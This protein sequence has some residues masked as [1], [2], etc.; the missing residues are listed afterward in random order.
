MSWTSIVRLAELGGA[1]RHTAGPVCVLADENGDWHAVASRCP[2]MG[3]PMEKGTLRKGVLT[4]AWHSWEFDLG[5]GGCYRGACADLP[6][7][8]LRIRDGAIEVDLDHHAAGSQEA[9]ITELR[10]RL[11]EGDRYQIARTLASALEDGI[12]PRT[13]ASA[14]ASHGIS[15]AIAAHQNSTA[16]RE[17]AAVTAAARLS[18]RFTGRDRLLPLLQGSLQVGNNVGSRR[19]ILPLPGAPSVARRAALLGRYVED[20]SELALERLL[21][22]WPRSDRERD[23]RLLR[24]ALGPEFL[25]RPEVPIDLVEAIDATRWLGDQPD[26]HATLVAW[27]LGKNRGDP[28]GE[29]RDAVA[30]L[31][32]HLDALPSAAAADAEVTERLGAVYAAHAPAQAL[33]AV[34][35]ILRSTSAR[36]VIGAFLVLETRRL[37]RLRPNNGGMWGSAI[38]GVRLAE[39]LQRLEGELPERT[40]ALGAIHL[41]WHA[42]SSRWLPLGKPWSDEHPAPGS[43]AAY[44][45]AVGAQDTATARA[46]GVA[47]AGR[48]RAGAAPWSEWIA[49]LIEEDIG[50]ERLLLLEAT[51]RTVPRIAEWQPLVAGVITHALDAKSRQDTAAAAR[52]GRSMLAS[53]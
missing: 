36:S 27:I 40:R 41:A 22:D 15:H 28:A 12:A 50:T 31:R 43:A 32:A 18:E 8:P 42:F 24:H 3:Y 53:A 5:T 26:I 48:C 2:H 1:S 6:I 44:A 34:L 49:P 33:D 52:F 4:C 25:P 39:A 7:F 17:I 9:R 30:W 29:D 45:E 46:E 10:D 19:A 51:L 13:L 37:T 47:L 20:A 35:E 21:M 38:T 16:T 11:L 23:A 14:V